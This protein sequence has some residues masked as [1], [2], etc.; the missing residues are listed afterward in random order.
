MSRLA[1]AMAA[2]AAHGE[3]KVRDGMARYGIVVSLSARKF[4]NVH[5]VQLPIGEKKSNLPANL[6]L[7][8]A[9]RSC[10]RRRRAAP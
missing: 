6:R 5:K 1:E 10:A 2:L 4:Q 7:V 3:A 9:S 8:E